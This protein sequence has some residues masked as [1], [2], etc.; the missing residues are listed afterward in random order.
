MRRRSGAVGHLG[1]GHLFALLSSACRV[2]ALSISLRPQGDYRPTHVWPR[3]KG[4]GKGNQKRI[5]VRPCL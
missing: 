2:L 5:E 3:G 4:K 1:F